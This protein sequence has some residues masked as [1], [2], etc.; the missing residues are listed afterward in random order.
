MIFDF[1]RAEFTYA[2]SDREMQCFSR[3]LALKTQELVVNHTDATAIYHSQLNG[4]EAVIIGLCI[5]T[6]ELIEREDIASAIVGLP[7][8][9]IQA[10]YDFTSRLSGKYIIIY[11]NRT[12]CYLL[13]DATCSIP[14]N[15]SGKLKDGA[16]C[17]S[18]FDKMTAGYFGCQPDLRLLK[19]RESADPAQTMPGELTPYQQVRALLPNQYLDVLTGEPVRVKVEIPDLL[20]D[21]V[22]DQ[23][24]RLSENTAK[25]F[26]KHYSLICPLTSGYDSRAVLAVL[27]QVLPD[28]HCYTTNFASPEDES[29]DMRI[30]SAICQKE[31]IEYTVFGYYDPP[32]EYTESLEKYAGLVNS[33]QTVK[34]AYSYLIDAGEKARINGNI[35]GQI[36]KSSVTNCVPDSLAT[37]SFF[38]CKI[39]NRDRECKAEMK[40][41]ADDIRN[42]GRQICDLFVYENR[43]GRWGGQEEALY[44]LCGMNSLNI[45]NSREIILSWIS[46]A[47][48]Q[49]IKKAIHL[50]M[51]RKTNPNLLTE[52]FNPDDRFSFLKNNWLFYYAATFAKQ[53]LIRHN[54]PCD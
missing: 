43:C 10:V 21:D 53:V 35:I 4:Q 14:A 15:Y 30:A 24:I 32:K 40:K 54:I 7:E 37:A 39:H 19:M 16:V 52:P 34:E 18:P 5:D 48:K 11:S 26:A 27:R 36:G 50:S 6:Y 13:G 20:F 23:S 12:G 25:Q 2:V 28:I 41:Y 46:V 1:N 44:S 3:H 42:S 45:F 33:S 22:I 51:I 29:D 17:I 31:G 9:T 49:R 38:T 8:Q 47:R